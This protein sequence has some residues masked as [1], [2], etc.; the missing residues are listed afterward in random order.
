[1][2]D[3][4]SRGDAG[5]AGEAKVKLAADG[6]IEAVS[7]AATPAS[8]VDRERVAALTVPTGWC[9][10]Y[11]LDDGYQRAAGAALETHPRTGEAHA[12]HHVSLSAQ[13]HEQHRKSHQDGRRHLI[14]PVA[15]VSRMEMR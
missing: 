6:S 1:M 8:S 13:A 12:M 14:R 9:S 11:Q 4:A 15:G 5:E 2:Q 7:A 10:W 3:T